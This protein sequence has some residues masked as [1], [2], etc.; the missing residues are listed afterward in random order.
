MPLCGFN[1]TMLK[2]LTLFA[3]GLYE[4]VVKRSEKDGV[5]VK[6]AMEIEVHEMNIFL[7]ALDEKYEELRKTQDVDEAMRNLVR[8]T[9][10]QKERR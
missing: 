6:T 5:D 1:A 9:K 2:G 4:Q 10:E 3:Q 7:P 8:W